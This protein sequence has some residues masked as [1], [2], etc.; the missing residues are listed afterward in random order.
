MSL[1]LKPFVEPWYQS[2]VDP[3]GAQKNVLQKL[4]QTYSKTDYG[5]KYHVNKIKTIQDFQTNFPIVSYNDLKPY[6]DKVREGNYQ[7]MLA[8]PPLCWVMTRGTTGLPKMIPVTKNHLSQIS[9]IGARGIINFALK[10]EDFE[11]LQGAVLNLNFPSKAGV[12]NTAEGD[13]L[14]GYSSG[15]YAKLNPRM[16]AT[17]LVPNQEEIDTLGGGIAK[18]E[19][20]ARFELIYQKSKDVDVMSTMGVTPVILAFA[21]FLKKN[22]VFFQRSFG[23]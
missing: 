19:W 5:K 22:M 23:R 9:S 17:R 16:G 13:G 7:A 20:E 10:R 2:L 6:L 1:F 8:E 4:T 11:V 12:M 3:T 21:R 14:Y 18:K 15:T